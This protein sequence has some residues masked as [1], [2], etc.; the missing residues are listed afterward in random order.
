VSAGL[1]RQA[2]HAE[3]IDQERVDVGLFGDPMG[4]W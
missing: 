3:L 2:P 1:A 4:E